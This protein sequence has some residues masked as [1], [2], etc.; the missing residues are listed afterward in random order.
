MLYEQIACK[1]E[2]V[3]VLTDEYQ[4]IFKQEQRKKLNERVH[5]KDGQHL[6]DPLLDE[7]ALNGVEWRAH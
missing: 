3:R 1:G 5:V 4:L 6:I 7:F 2:D